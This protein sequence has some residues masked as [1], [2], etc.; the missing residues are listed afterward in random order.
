MERQSEILQEWRI[1]HPD[2][3]DIPLER[4]LNS[5]YGSSSDSYFSYSSSCSSFSSCSDIKELDIKEETKDEMGAEQD[6]PQIVDIKTTFDEGDTSQKD[7]KTHG[8]IR[9]RSTEE[10]QMKN[11]KLVSVECNQDINGSAFVYGRDIERVLG[12]ALRPDDVAR[13]RRVCEESNQKGPTMKEEGDRRLYL[14]VNMPHKRA[15]QGLTTEDAGRDTKAECINRDGEGGERKKDVGNMSASSSNTSHVW[16]NDQRW[17]RKLNS[18]NFAKL[19]DRHKGDGV[20]SRGMLRNM[21]VV[22]QFMYDKLELWGKAMRKKYKKNVSHAGRVSD[23][24]RSMAQASSHSNPSVYN[25]E[26]AGETTGS[27]SLDMQDGYSKLYRS[28]VY[29]MLCIMYVF[30]NLYG[31]MFIV[32]ELYYPAILCGCYIF[33]WWVLLI[34]NVVTGKFDWFFTLSVL[35]GAVQPFLVHILLGG[36][37]RSGFCAM[38]SVQ[39]PAY[40]ILFTG[41][42]RRAVTWLIPL[43]FALIMSL[44]LELT[45]VLSFFN[46]EDHIRSDVDPD[47]F[48]S[49]I[50]NMNI[51]LLTAL[52]MCSSLYLTAKVSLLL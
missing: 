24:S 21:R 38:W 13:F 11:R 31:V 14:T 34:F 42:T 36:A 2:E 3:Q 4:L 32:M 23:A 16:D 20:G 44:V 50:A 43:L 8:T 39:G 47:T 12:T 46:I 19:H 25:K 29:M 6:C 18:E 7:N 35:N 26:G 27:D 17:M 41:N 40:I 10:P 49:V 28:S 45:G 33:I 48:I 37:V 30:A 1:N 5:S 51:I 9:K 15:G 22:A 52:L